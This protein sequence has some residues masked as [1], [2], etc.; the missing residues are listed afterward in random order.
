MVGLVLVSSPRN[1]TARGIARVIG[2]SIG[3]SVAQ[4]IS[5]TLGSLTFVR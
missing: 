1:S 4:S 2:S 3:I 5:G